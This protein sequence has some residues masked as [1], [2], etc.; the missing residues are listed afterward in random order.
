MFSDLPRSEKSKAFRH[1]NQADVCLA[2]GSSLSVTPAAD[3]PERVAE[4]N[5]KLIIGNLQRTCLHKMSSLNIYA[6]TDTIMEGVMKRLNI[7]IP[8]WI[9]RRCVR[10]QIKHEK[11]NN[12]YQILIEGR[13][14]DKDLPFSMFKSIIVKTPKSEYLLKKE[15][16]SISI[17]MNVQDTKN[18]AKI[19]L[20]LNFFEHYNE[21]PYLLE[22]PL[23]DINEEFYLFW[24]PT[25]GVWVRKERADEN[26]TQ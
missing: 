8:P 19:Q 2:L 18:E 5:Q 4:R 20:Q 6:F 16:F 25:T 22:Y 11:L 15:P 10:F 14:S 7:T 26:L 13:D 1:A 24:N 12:C 17:D 3:V 21:I 23:E 9:L